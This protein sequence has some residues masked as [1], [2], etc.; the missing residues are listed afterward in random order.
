MGGPGFGKQGLQTLPSLGLGLD[1]GQL[2]GSLMSLPGAR[3]WLCLQ[4]TPVSAIG[5]SK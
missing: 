3:P 4:F 1:W 5:T 2:I